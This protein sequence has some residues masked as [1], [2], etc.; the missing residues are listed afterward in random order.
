ML[1]FLVIGIGLFLLYKLFMGD[2][3]KREMDTEKETKRQVKEGTMSKDPV[4]GTYVSIDD[5]LRVRNA[6]EVIHF[7]SYECRDKYLKQIGSTE[8]HKTENEDTEE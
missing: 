4:C 3:K 6:G 1:K 7:C 5:S 8:I 2:K